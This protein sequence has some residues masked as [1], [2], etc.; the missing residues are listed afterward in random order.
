MSSIQDILNGL[1]EE[2]P[3]ENANPKSH[4]M[5]E[6]QEGENQMILDADQRDY[7]DVQCPEC[8]IT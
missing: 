2:E 4:W 7:E 6:R 5:R 8:M 3:T 1:T